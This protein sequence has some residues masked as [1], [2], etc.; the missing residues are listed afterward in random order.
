MVILVGL[1]LMVE[2]SHFSS[3]SSRSRKVGGNLLWTKILVEVKYSRLPL[4]SLKY[5]ISF[6]TSS[7]DNFIPVYSPSSNFNFVHVLFFFY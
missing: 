5:L 7:S 6:D 1:S 3:L 2:Y 4:S